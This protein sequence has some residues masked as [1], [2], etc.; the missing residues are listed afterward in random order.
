MGMKIE[1]VGTTYYTVN[2]T[3]EDVKK[4]KSWIEEH[5]E[6]LL[7]FDMEKNICEAVYSLYSDGE[8]ELYGG[9][10]ETESDFNT[11]EV[12]WSEFENRTAEEILDM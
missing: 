9:G 1:V 10:K 4:V 8:I 11:D 7:S 12:N 6:E 5:K 2:L 3:D